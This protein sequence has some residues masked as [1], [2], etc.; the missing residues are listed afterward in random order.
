M[1]DRPFVFCKSVP[2]GTE[3]IPGIWENKNGT[4]R[5]P[6]NAYSVLGWPLPNVEE[7]SDE[8]VSAFLAG[9]QLRGDLNGFAKEHQK[10]MLRKAFQVLT[11]GRPQVQVRRWWG[12]STQQA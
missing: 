9:P 12:W 4:Y 8:K 3:D 1:R 6:L 7:V 5:V 10:K 2:P 11:V